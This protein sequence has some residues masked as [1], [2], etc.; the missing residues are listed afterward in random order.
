VTEGDLKDYISTF[1]ERRILQNY[2]PRESYRFG[3]KRIFCISKFFHSGFAKLQCC[4]A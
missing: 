4:A 1:Y 2:I 3:G